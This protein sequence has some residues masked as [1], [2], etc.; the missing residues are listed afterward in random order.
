M[1]APTGRAA[2]DTARPAAVAVAAFFLAFA[3]GAAAQDGV[4]TDRAALEA[5]YDAAGGVDWN[6]STNWKTAAPLGE[7]HGVTTDADGRVTDLLL[8]RNGLA[9][10]IPDAL[11]SLTR[12]RHLNLA[13]NG[14][15]GQIPD[16]LGD[17]TDLQSLSL[18]LNTLTGPIPPRLGVLSR[19][20][21]LDLGVNR[22]TGPIPDELGNLANLDELL[23]GLNTLTG[24]IPPR[25]GDLSRLRRLDLGGNKLT[26]PIPDELGNLANLDELLVGL[27]TLTGSIPPRLGDL[28]RL[29]RLDLGGNKLTGPIPDGLGNLTDLSELGLDVNA[30]SGPIPPWLGNLTRL[31]R[32]KLQQNG[33]SGSIPDA[34]G[35]LT[36]LELLLFGEN[37][38]LTG[39]LPDGLRLSRLRRLSTWMTRA[40][41][42]VA[43]RAW[44]ET[45]DYLGS[46]CQPV[47][48]A[49]VDVA[50]VYTP[51]TRRAAGGTE[52][53]E[54]LIDLLI[55]ETNESFA[56]SGVRHRV[57]L[58]ARAEL[59][60]EES[61]D[62]RVDLFRLRDPSDGH[63]DEAHTLRDRSRA[64]LVH[65][66]V[67]SPGGA[68]FRSNAYGASFWN[69]GTGAF[70]HELG[71]NM[72]LSH[73]RYI[74]HN[75]LPQPGYGYVN[76]RGLEAGAPPSS[77]WRTMMS[78]D[79]QCRDAGFSCTKLL[80]FSNPRQ[81]WNGDPLGVRFEPDAFGVAGPADAAV[82]LNAT[83]PLVAEWRDRVPNRPPAAVA[84]AL[85]DRRLAP[86]SAVALDLSQAFVDPDGDAL[87]Y[88]ASSAAPGV[89][90]VIAAGAR[91]TLT[92]VSLGTAGIRVTASDG[93][94]LSAEQRFTATV[95]AS[96]FTDDP[97]QP[98]V[99][100]IRAVH[101]TELRSRT[102]GLRRG[103]GLAAF[104][105][106]DPV[107]TA[108]ATWIKLAHL[109]EVR[110]ALAEAYAAAGR[111]AQRWT[112]A[113][114]MV[115]APVRGAHVMEL[116]AAVL[117]LE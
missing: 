81:A 43:W 31:K 99:T 67:N 79:R 84:G 96:A 87:L 75:L 17:L 117:A 9:G 56:A 86:N 74:A 54:A 65:L 27:N 58:A 69:W 12:L 55:A 44:L 8:S 63:M 26:G 109:L 28:S 88:T 71:H 116:R 5:L 40:C 11:G 112:D 100:P 115:G 82:I 70:A 46:L 105:W 23:V 92:G 59:P 62:I 21:R 68:A 35:N 72:G 83:A 85:P 36:S 108:G 106:T 113:D 13:V 25:L 94:G 2:A 32:L 77:R 41:A 78:Y 34:L 80:R 93:A 14:L 29:R 38:G 107:L 60:Y 7:W 73:D 6:D 89:V 3:A 24:S 95:T 102:D 104:A 45:I 42:P 90:S 19:L 64:D 61:H 22:L 15:T 57:A 4:E 52:A 103:A 114:P 48:A 110:S 16:A 53:I 20:T 39:P 47:T 1:L 30:L 18:A 49:T 97:I 51:A 66:L 10:T 76:Q 33:F 50:V 98:G 101:F 111:P 91:V 37:W